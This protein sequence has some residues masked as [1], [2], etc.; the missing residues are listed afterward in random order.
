MGYKPTRVR[1]QSIIEARK[2]AEEKQGNVR[3]A[4]ARGL[5]MRRELDE[6][7]VAHRKKYA[8][9]ASPEGSDPSP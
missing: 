5:Q 4:V 2:A 1:Y 3:V 6:R 7:K 8:A 9:P